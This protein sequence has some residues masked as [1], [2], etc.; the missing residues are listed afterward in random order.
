MRGPTALMANRQCLDQG[1]AGASVSRKPRQPRQK[2][3]I[4]KSS[5]TDGQGRPIGDKLYNPDIPGAVQCP[6][7]TSRGKRCRNVVAADS[8]SCLLHSSLIDQSTS[9]STKVPATKKGSGNGSIGGGTDAPIVAFE[10]EMEKAWTCLPQ[11]T[12]LSKVEKKSLA[13]EI[14][15]LTPG[16]RI[17][18]DMMGRKC[19]AEVL[20]I[21]EEMYTVFMSYEDYPNLYNEYLPFDRLRTP[22]IG[23]GTLT[24]MNPENIRP[25]ALAIALA[26]ER[27]DVSLHYWEFPLLLQSIEYDKHA[28]VVCGELYKRFDMIPLS[29][30]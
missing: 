4:N 14:D 13:A 19:T 27:R 6:Q 21:R 8:N 10:S 20:E 22:S 30:S 11:A 26:G 2:Q 29:F 9:A 18:V 12:Q 3:R 17:S 7:I 24:D 16:S 23:G 28:S 1:S 25:G 15:Q 5:G